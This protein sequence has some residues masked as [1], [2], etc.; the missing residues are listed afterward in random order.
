MRV[1]DWLLHLFN[2]LMGRSYLGGRLAHEKDTK[3]E[4]KIIRTTRRHAKAIH[5][6]E[7]ECFSDPW[8]LKALRYEIS[9]PHSVCLIASDNHKK[10][11]G[12]V[13]MR[14]IL[15]EGHINNIAV[16]TDAR[17]QGIGRLLL[18]TLISEAT[19]LGI[20]ALTLE[21]RSQNHAAISLYKKLGFETCGHR[22][23]YY[24]KPTDDAL[25]MWKENL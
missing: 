1:K 11:L 16:A 12:H 2:H 13:T 17:R 25:V 5:T 24:H 7:K 3:A 22:K 9:H 23:N 20:T 4:I 10:V 19:A 14:H 8:S 15:N 21:V 6:L 18:E